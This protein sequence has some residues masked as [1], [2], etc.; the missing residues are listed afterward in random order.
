MVNTTLENWNWVSN[1]DAEIIYI[2]QIG[3]EAPQLPEKADW[4]DYLIRIKINGKYYTGELE[5]SE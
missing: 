5:L 2:K 4:A 3:V 1:M